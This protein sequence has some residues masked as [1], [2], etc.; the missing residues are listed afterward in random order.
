M[1]VKKNLDNPKTKTITI[2]DYKNIYADHKR[3]D[4]EKITFSK[5]DGFVLP[6]LI[7]IYFKGS[8]F[9]IYEN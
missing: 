4:L 2:N 8:V 7:L 9:K 1:V 3:N 6:D 5:Q